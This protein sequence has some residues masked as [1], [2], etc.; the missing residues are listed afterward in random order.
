MHP[1]QI[2]VSRLMVGHTHEVSNHKIFTILKIMFVFLKDIDEKFGR[3]WKRLRDRYLHSP[4]EYKKG[5]LS[6]LSHPTEIPEVIDVF[7]IPNYDKL[8][9]GCMDPYFGRIFKEIWTQHCFMFEKGEL[10]LFIWYITFLTNRLQ[11]P[12]AHSFR[13]ELDLFT[14]FTQRKRWS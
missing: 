3:L 12:L 8:F 2:I 13:L 11:F 6:V 14:N 5:V 1:F 10:D 7:V 4:E 9:R